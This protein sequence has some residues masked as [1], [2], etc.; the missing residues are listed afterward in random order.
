MVDYWKLGGVVAVVVSVLGFVA[1]IFIKQTVVKAIDLQFD[2]R[3]AAFV[4]ELNVKEHVH[5]ELH[6]RRLAAIDAMRTAMRSYLECINRFRSEMIRNQSQAE[7]DRSFHPVQTE[8]RDLINVFHQRMLDLPSNLL[9]D[10]REYMQSVLAYS[11]HNL[12]HASHLIDVR[13]TNLALVEKSV[14]EYYRESSKRQQTEVA[15][16]HRRLDRASNRIESHFRQ[17]VGT[18]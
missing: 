9:D 12:E 6:N 11:M 13:T 3:L 5:T 1:R 15:E 2:R 18:D 4:S 16:A 8:E 17:I 7:L 10:C 14:R